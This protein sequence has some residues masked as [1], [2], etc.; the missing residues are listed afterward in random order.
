MTLPL[1]LPRGFN[2]K[3]QEEGSRTKERRGPGEGTASRIPE[4]LRTQLIRP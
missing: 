2:N 4:K 3:R 1:Q